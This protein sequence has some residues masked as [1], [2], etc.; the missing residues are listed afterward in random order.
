MYAKI[1]TLTPTTEIVEDELTRTREFR[2]RCIN[3]AKWLTQLRAPQS[4]I[5]E[6]WRKSKLTY[7]EYKNELYE[8]EQEKQ[9]LNKE[10]AKHN[11]I[12]K[13]IVDEIYL[14]ESK[15]NY[16]SVI[17]SSNIRFNMAIDPLDFMSEDDFE[18]DLYLT[19]LEHAKQIYRDRFESFWLEDEKLYWEDDMQEEN[20]D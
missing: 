10:Y 8:A 6:E 20:Y 7:R 3:N 5:D 18:Y 12:Q 14:R 15:L 17:Y 13:S 9:K 4:L 2:E 16:Q 11:P 1:T 19:F